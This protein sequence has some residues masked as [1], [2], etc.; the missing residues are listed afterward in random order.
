MESV[1]D[2]GSWEFTG[3]TPDGSM[4]YTGYTVVDAGIISNE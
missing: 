4:E 3:E 1:Y 2:Y